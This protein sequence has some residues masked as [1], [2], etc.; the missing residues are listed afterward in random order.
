MSLNELINLINFRLW[1]FKQTHQ[2]ADYPPA[3]WIRAANKAVSLERFH[4]RL[5]RHFGL[6]D[7]N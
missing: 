6:G 7:L 1:L 5:D 2:T 3:E 4:Q